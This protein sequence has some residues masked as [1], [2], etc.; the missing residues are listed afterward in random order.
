MNI[1]KLKIGLGTLPLLAL[2]ACQRGP[3]AELPGFPDKSLQFDMSGVG[4]TTVSNTDVYVFDGE[5]AAQG[6][7]NHKVLNIDRAGD[8]LAMN[9]PQGTW[10]LFLLSAD[11]NVRADMQNP[12]RGTDRAT[13]KMVEFAA[14]DG[15]EPFTVK[16]PEVRTAR[17]DGQ[18]I[19]ANQQQTV[20]STLARNAAMIKVV[21]ADVSGV[22]NGYSSHR[23]EL[24]NVPNA[25]SWSGSLWPDKDNPQV[26]GYPMFLPLQISTD[27]ATGRQYSDT[28]TFIVPA[29]VGTDYL[30]SSP[31]DTST[32]KLRVWLRLHTTAGD[33]EKEAEL[34]LVP[35]ANKIIVARLLVK[36]DLTFQTTIE[37]WTDTEMDATFGQTALQI[38]KTNV[39]LAWKDTVYVKASKSLSV[40]PEASWLTVQAIDAERVE[41][42]GNVDDYDSPRFTYVNF[43]AGNVT[44]R[45][46]V[47]QRPNNAGTINFRPKRVILSPV[48]PSKSDVFVDCRNTWRLFPSE[49][50]SPSPSTGTGDYCVT[51]TRKTSESDLSAYGNE[52]Y[53]VRNLETLDTSRIELCNL[54]LDAPDE[55]YVGNPMMSMDTTVWNDEITALGASGSFKVEDKPDWVTEATVEPDGRLKIVAQ[56][57]PQEEAREGMMTIVHLD[58]PD[59]KVQV[60][61]IQDVI[62]RIPEFDYFTLKFTWKNNDVDIAVEFADNNGAAFD[63][64]PVGWSKSTSVNYNGQ[65][66]LQW[67]GDATGGQGETAFFNAP[68]VN[69]DNTIP[70]KLNLDVYATWFSTGRAPDTMGFTMYAYKGGTMVKNPDGKNYDN[71]GGQLVYS[72]RFQVMITTTQGKDTYATG[73]YTYV[74]RLTYDKVKHSARVDLKA[75]PS[76]LS[77]PIPYRAPA[78]VPDEPK[79]AI[80][81]KPIYVYSN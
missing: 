24:K 33:I 72:Q 63:K 10:D 58:D 54:F 12:V 41:L 20:P 23:I 80:E 16:V 69:S 28:M 44:K 68:V 38:S 56:R 76:T 37:D 60:K 49:K 19:V 71:V 62:V 2:L 7:F 55:I 17:I 45:V 46:R 8:R 75:T 67:G 35:K 14:W 25:L 64:K 4:R 39:G 81:H 61:V 70:R 78:A 18:V 9:V 26:G 36:S 59:Y 42:T 1:D 50:V 11:P 40:T 13:Q 52:F 47:D 27:P 79:P 74:A 3:E 48:H 32:H 43:T 21:V 73:G 29:H 31:A 22:E 53:T 57:D 77:A 66:L 65:L 6:Q 30:A 5:G 15:S 34:P 51:L